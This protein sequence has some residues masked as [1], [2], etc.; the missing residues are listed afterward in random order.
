MSTD[1]SASQDWE[2]LEDSYWYVPTPY[3]AAFALVTGSQQGVV[4]LV[5]Q[6]LWH[7]TKVVDGYVFGQVATT[8]GNGWVYS[9]LVGSVAPSGAV[10]FSFTQ[11]GAD[12]EV[13]VGQGQMVESGGAWYFEMQMTTGSGSASV[14]HWAY[15]AAAEPGDRAWSV[16]PGYTSTGIAAAFDTDTSN[17]A[18]ASAAQRIVIGTDDGDQLGGVAAPNGL[19]IY[20]ERGGDQL[21]G[22]DL[23]DGLVGGRGGDTLAGGGGA[24]DLFG[25]D[26]TDTLDGGSGDDLLSGDAGRDTL[27]GGDGDDRLVGGAGSDVLHG[28]SGDDLFVFSSI[29]EM[30][31]RAPDRIEDFATGKDRIDLTPIDTRPNTPADEAFAFLGT[32]A[33]DGKRGELRYA[34]G[35]GETTVSGDLDG[36]KQ[37]D[38]TITLLGRHTLS[39]SDFML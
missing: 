29:G 34:L 20:G 23:A 6:T 22:D 19:L 4:P 17:D 26:G 10:S 25:Q 15:M 18:G 39:A 1:V 13:T 31:L 8:L 27:D 9:T 28:G 16:L 3:L 12:A 5:D 32:A 11:D 36:D 37:A 38:F 14:T 24:D 35:D 30:P 21:T 33:F 2:F 7:I